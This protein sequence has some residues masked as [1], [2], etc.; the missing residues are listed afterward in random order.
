M[1][2][3]L[4]PQSVLCPL[5]AGSQGQDLELGL[6]IIAREKC[7]HVF[8]EETIQSECKKSKILCNICN[9]F[10]SE[11]IIQIM[12]SILLNNRSRRFSFSNKI[13]LKENIFC[14]GWTVKYFSLNN[15]LLH[16]RVNV[17]IIKQKVWMM[18]WQIWY[19]DYKSCGQKLYE[20]WKMIEH[21]AA[22]TVISS[23]NWR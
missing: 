10:N 23:D 4:D 17:C 6:N 2:P 12:F 21:F 20:I 3:D 5:V 11:S 19:I 14:D 8:S 16:W 7:T 1:V 13:S 9:Y 22:P 18:F 15:K